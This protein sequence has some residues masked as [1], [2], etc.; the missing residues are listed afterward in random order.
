MVGNHGHLRYTPGFYPSTDVDR[1]TNCDVCKPVTQ[2]TTMNRMKFIGLP[3]AVIV[4]A[5]TGCTSTGPMVSAS[6]SDCCTPI[7]LDFSSYGLVIWDSP[8]F[9][10]PYIEDSISHVLSEKGLSRDDKNPDLLATLIYEQTDLGEERQMD[11]FEGHLA[12][13][14]DF[15]FIAVIRVEVKDLKH[16]SIIWAGTISRNHDVYVGEYMHNRRGRAAIYQALKDLFSGFP[17]VSG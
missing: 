3:L 8:V 7:D 14:G 16:N 11:A 13:G 10:Q 6:R 1:D 15:R 17:E 12:P 2:E 4:F 9:L 5:I